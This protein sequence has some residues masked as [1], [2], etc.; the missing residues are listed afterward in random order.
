MSGDD[1]EDGFEESVPTDSARVPD[2]SLPKT[3]VAPA[4]VRPSKLPPP[5]RS[6][7]IPDAVTDR[8]FLEDPHP[9]QE[10]S[11]IDR[12]KLQDKRI[13][14]AVKAVQFEV[15]VPEPVIEAPKSVPMAPLVVVDEEPEGDWGANHTRYEAP[16]DRK[17]PASDSE[18]V[19]SLVSFL[20]RHSALR[21]LP[22]HEL[23]AVFARMNSIEVPSG[24]TVYQA[25]DEAGSVYVF[26]SGRLEVESFEHGGQSNKRDARAGEVFGIRACMQSIKH[27]D[28]L[29][30][31]EDARL[32]LISE[33]ALRELCGELE[34]LR[35]LVDEGIRGDLERTPDLD[36]ER[37][38]TKTKRE[39]APV[40]S[41]I[42]RPSL[43]K[44]WM[45]LWILGGVIAAVGLVRFVTR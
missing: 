20:T 35:K 40:T 23:R 1:S 31:L 2:I 3:V 25:G 4:P 8:D 9:T 12:G 43:Q 45:V 26:E 39:R 30:V 13:E 37:A 32:L 42:E 15:E 36:R 17:M 14:A 34:S 28:T 27:S 16:S 33:E 18:H 41:P 5:S 29:R 7:K 38:P 21:A 10:M 44:L 6:S 22:L 24:S 11:A 19:R